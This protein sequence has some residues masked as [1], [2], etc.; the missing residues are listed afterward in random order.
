MQ[1]GVNR[2]LCALVCACLSAPVCACL[3]ACP[4][5]STPIYA[6]SKPIYAPIYRSQRFTKQVISPDAELANRVRSPSG[7]RIRRVS[8]RRTPLKPFAVH[9]TVHTGGL[10]LCV[11]DYLCAQIRLIY[12]ASYCIHPMQLASHVRSPSGVRI[13]RVSQEMNSLQTFR[14]ARNCAHKWSRAM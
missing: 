3:R 1:I 2:R 8:H 10:V 4:R 11:P 5:L 9:G 13:R 6:L 7:V 14:R 12:S